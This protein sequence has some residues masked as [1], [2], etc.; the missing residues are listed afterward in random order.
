M[1]AVVVACG[2][3]GE[4]PTSTDASTA[5]TATETAITA[6]ATDAESSSGTASSSTDTSSSGTNADTSSSG[7]ETTACDCAADEV[8][9]EQGTDGCFEP[10]HPALSCVP[11]P[12]GCSADA[13]CGTECAWEICGGPD[14]GG[15]NGSVCTHP[16]PGYVC[17]GFTGNCNLFTQDCDELERCASWDGNADGEYDRTRC[18]PLDPRPAQVGEPC[19]S[20][21]SHASGID[22]CVAGA[23]CLS[24]DPT[25]VEGICRAAC[26]GNPFTATCDDPAMEC[27]ITEWFFAWCLPA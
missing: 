22:N 12:A 24:D 11:M 3:E 17:G 26:V 25:E 1:L 15:A 10:H 23:M 5:S 13:A 4:V 14:C 19:V 9:V 8:C 6:S 2:G 27:V 7:G 20:E 16:S 21:G 18:A